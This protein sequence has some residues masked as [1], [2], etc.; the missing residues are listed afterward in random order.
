MSDDDSSRL[1]AEE[2]DDRHWMKKCCG[3]CPYS[4]KDTLFVHPDRA[5]DFAF[6]ASNPFGNFPCHKTADLVEDDDGFGEYVHGEKS[7]TCHGFFALQAAENWEE[8]DYSENGFT[9][10]VNA[11]CDPWEMIEHHT[12][13]WE[14]ER[15]NITPK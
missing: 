10:D 11:F 12:Q 4:K 9:P 1:K 6:S 7:F 2:S 8:K 13:K 3:L 15:G 14:T 5:E